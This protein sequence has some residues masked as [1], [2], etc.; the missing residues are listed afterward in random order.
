MSDFLDAVESYFC[1]NG[2]LYTRYANQVMSTIDICGTTFSMDF[3]EIDDPWAGTLVL[4]AGPFPVPNY[5]DEAVE[6][7]ADALCDT[8]WHAGLGY[9]RKDKS[10]TVTSHIFL[11]GLIVSD[12]DLEFLIAAAVDLAGKMAVKMRPL[13]DGRVNFI[14]AFLMPVV[15]ISHLP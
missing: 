2:F 5:K 7:L 11:E 12:W 6:K 14:Q 13:A 4:V 15:L 10:I 9:S 3:S 1:A 8:S